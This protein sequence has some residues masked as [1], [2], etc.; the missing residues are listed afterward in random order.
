MRIIF[1]IYF[2]Y[3]QEDNL[4]NK[5]FIGGPRTQTTS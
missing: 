5:M 1:N 2:D 4:A 3:N